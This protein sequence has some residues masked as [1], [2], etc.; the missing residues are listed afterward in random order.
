MSQELP[1]VTHQKKKKNI[2]GGK[3]VALGGK[4]KINPLFK[5]NIPAVYM[6]RRR[7]QAV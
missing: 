2:L 3:S 5:P 1:Q 4:I 6:K 7:K